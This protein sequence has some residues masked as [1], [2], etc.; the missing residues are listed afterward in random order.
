MNCKRPSRVSVQRVQTRLFPP[1]PAL[2]AGLLVASA[3]S[4]QAPTTTVPPPTWTVEGDG[5][6][7]GFAEWVAPAG[8]V[9][10][11]GFADVLVGQSGHGANPGRVLIYA[12]STNGL[13]LVPAWEC[14]APADRQRHW[15]GAFAVGVGDVNNDGWADVVATGSADSELPGPLVDEAYLFLGS[16]TG[17]VNSAVWRF[18]SPRDDQGG[19]HTTGSVG[20]VNA[21]GCSDL[22][23][24]AARPGAGSSV[25]VLYGSPAG[26]PAAPDRRWHFP[27]SRPDPRVRVAAA[28]DVNGDGF[29]DMIVGELFWREGGQQPGRA[30]VYHGSPSGLSETPAWMATVPATGTRPAEHLHEQSFG[31]SVAAIGDVDRDGYGDVVI[32]APFA[33]NGDFYEGLAFAYHGSAQGL[34]AI[35]RWQQEGNSRHAGFGWEVG[36]GDFN[37]DG[38]ADVVAGAPY[39]SFGEPAHASATFVF[40]GSHSGTSH[41]PAWSQAGGRG[42]RMVGCN[43][44]CAGD[45]NADGFDDLLVGERDFQRAS[46]IV[47]RARVFYGGV[48]GLTGSSG[49]SLDKPWLTR[50]QQFH[51]RTPFGWKL[52]GGGALLMAAAGFFVAWRRALGRL[53]HSERETARAQERERLARNLHDQ[54]GA[55]LG[56]IAIVSNL[57]GGSSPPREQ[58][59]TNIRRITTLAQT[60]HDDLRDLV[61]TLDSSH[62]PLEDVAGRLTSVAEQHLEAAS[63]RF[64]ADIP[65]PLPALT[66]PSEIRRELVM[67]ATEALHN[68]V[69]HA[70][71]RTVTLRLRIEARQLHLTIADDGCGFAPD[72]LPARPSG[73]T[74]GHGLR[75]FKARMDALGGRL[76]IVSQPGHGT[77]VRVSVPLAKP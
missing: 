15:F 63:I 77:S 60:A 33:E 11:D 10:G 30:L 28:G 42:E 62:D 31:W 45:V 68:V 7:P 52:A 26:L 6:T 18:P 67:I 71:A 44:A 3:L 54:L 38:L 5:E 27:D 39:H 48:A 37:G 64:A 57:T 12:G 51:D 2:A 41:Q 40:A 21:D 61:W 25:L 70:Q 20:D 29:S 74:N 46:H 55:T 14:S 76:E 9:N 36:G 72:S 34:E 35:A 69:Q 16:A 75:N 32:G 22:Y 59:E 13:G 50:L 53:R 56:R 8:D 43:V 23:L 65:N 73:T 58:L 4:A 17:L 1:L 47:G 24:V 66:L 49:L 19:L